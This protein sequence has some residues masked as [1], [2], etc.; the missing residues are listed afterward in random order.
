MTGKEISYNIYIGE[1][2]GNEQCQSNEHRVTQNA[3]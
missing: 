2:I 3:T 1:V